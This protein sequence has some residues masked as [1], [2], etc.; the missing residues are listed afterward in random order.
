MKNLAL[1]FCSLRPIQLSEEVNDAREN[2][3]LICLQQ[4]KR[5]IPD[6]FDLL[7][8]ENTID[9]PEEIKSNELRQFLSESEMCVTGSE[10]NI[11]TKNKGMGELLMLKTALEETD[12]DNYKN[13]SYISARKLYTCPYVFERTERLEKQALLSNPDLVFLN[14]NFA[15]THKQGMYN[16][17]FFSM[18][19][20]VMLDYA[21]YAIN[22]I[23][24]NSS[25]G[26]GSEQLLYNFVNENKIEYEWLNW[27]GIVR[28]DWE[29]NQK[30]LDVNN[31]H[32]C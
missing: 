30:V 15:K 4:L 10:G 25:Q 16:D 6:S 23:K 29:R 24:T 14:G 9:D 28:N 22:Y 7:I 21:N 8:C 5:V 12:L 11:G 17:M 19:S 13:I 27:L 31:F 32:I 20:S 26:V 3:Y 2:E 18:S 1:G